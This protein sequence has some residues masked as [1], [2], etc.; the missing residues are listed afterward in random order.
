MQHPH[1]G[2]R[3]LYVTLKSKVKNL[4]DHGVMEHCAY[5]FLFLIEAI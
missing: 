1:Y 4:L 5:S 2:F 3:S